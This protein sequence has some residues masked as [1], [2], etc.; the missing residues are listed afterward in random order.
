VIPRY[1]DQK[2]PKFEEIEEA[3]RERL[4]DVARKIKQFL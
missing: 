3:Q 1:R 2:L 4:D